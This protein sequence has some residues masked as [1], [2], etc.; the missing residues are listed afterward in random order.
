[1][2][3]MCKLIHVDSCLPFCDTTQVKIYKDEEC[4]NEAQ[5]TDVIRMN[6]VELT[7]E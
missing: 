3:D 2:I 5:Q 7:E 4:I 1:M 6:P